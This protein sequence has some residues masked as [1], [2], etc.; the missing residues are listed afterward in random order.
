MVEQL[1]VYVSLKNLHNIFLSNMDEDIGTW[2]TN[3]HLN[4]VS[5][6]VV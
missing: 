6:Y 4:L 5:S 2:I 1:P 3:E